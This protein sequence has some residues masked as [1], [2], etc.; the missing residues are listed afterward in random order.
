MLDHL[1]LEGHTTKFGVA[2]NRDDDEE[3]TDWKL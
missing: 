2:T 1:N 3:D